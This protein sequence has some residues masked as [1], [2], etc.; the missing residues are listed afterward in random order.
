VVDLYPIL[1]AANSK[2]EAWGEGAMLAFLHSASSFDCSQVDFDDGPPE[3]WGRLI[4]GDTQL[5]AHRLIPLAFVAGGDGVRIEALAAVQRV[6]LQRVPD[7]RSP[8]LRGNGVSVR[9]VIP[10]ILS[11]AID[12]DR[13]SVN[14]FWWSTVTA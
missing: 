8:V 7:F 1:E 5:L 13:M 9:Q 10:V 14:D 12:F 2:R 6:V 4:G 3:N 11:S